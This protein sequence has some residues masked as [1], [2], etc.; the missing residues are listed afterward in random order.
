MNHQIQI[1][2][3]TIMSNQIVNIDRLQM[4]KIAV[5]NI[6]KRKK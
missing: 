5:E 2:G 1:K 6:E 4:I 3:I